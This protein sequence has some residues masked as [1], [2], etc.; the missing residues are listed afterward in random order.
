MNDQ[1]NAPRE[2]GTYEIRDGKR[3]LVTPATKDHPEGNRAREADGTPVA[4]AD[5]RAFNPAP[6]IDEAAA[7]NAAARASEHAPEPARRGKKGA[8]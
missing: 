2:G 8:E 4:G 6:Q 1:D 7:A 3:V 5:E